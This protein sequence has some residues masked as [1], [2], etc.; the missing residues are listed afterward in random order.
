[1]SAVLSDTVR[2]LEVYLYRKNNV[3]FENFSCGF[4]ILGRT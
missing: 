3:E 4:K 1:M 2:F